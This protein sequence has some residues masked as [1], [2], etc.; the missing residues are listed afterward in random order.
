MEIRTFLVPK[1]GSSDTECE[2]AVC[3]WSADDASV[4]HF[5]AVCDGA[6][7]SLL[8]GAW[9]RVLAGDAI[10][11]MSLADRW[12]EHVGLFAEDLVSRAGRHWDTFLADYQADRTA[13][14]RPIEWYE[15]PGLDKGAFATVLAVQLIP[16]GHG[17][18]WRAFALGDSCLFQL[19]DHAVLRSFPIQDP[20]AFGTTP[21]LLGS[22]NRDGVLVAD[23]LELNRGR[24]RPG[25]EL[26]LVT[27]A[28]AAWLLTPD[29]G[30]E[31]S[32]RGL[33]A[34]SE[35]GVDDFAEW[36]VDQRVRGRMRNDDVAMVR[37][38]VEAAR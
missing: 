10:E 24:V 14:G 34:V 4:G 5:A 1:T 36:V 8:A 17:W 21:A 26:L 33:A 7:E 12:W 37:L 30:S 18:T 23:R 25:D 15:Q 13:R 29:G 38:R 32:L 27:D 11:S 19:R 35:L 6:S 28:L 3:V 9:A 2:D 16:R 20:A 31:A 22:R